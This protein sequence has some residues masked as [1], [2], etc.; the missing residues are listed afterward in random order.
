M[1]SRISAPYGPVRV[2]LPIRRIVREVGAAW[3]LFGPSRSFASYTVDIAASRL[4]RFSRRPASSL[5]HVVTRSGTQ[6]Y[7]RRNRG[8]IY[9]IKEIFMD[10]VYRLPSGHAPDVVVDLG[11]HIGLTTLWMA[12]TYKPSTI[13]AVEPAPSNAALARRNISA[14]GVHAEL[15]EAAIATSEGTA[16]FRE[17]PQSNLGQLSDIGT[18]VR[19][20]DIASVLARVPNDGRVDL[21]KIDIEGGESALFQGDV[22]WLSK[23]ELIVA[24]LHPNAADTI[25]ITTL[26]EGNGFRA[27]DLPGDPDAHTVCFERNRAR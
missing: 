12:E 25:A 3:R 26:L 8:D 10:D 2:A 19:T 11:A 9:A 22:S 15:V 14:N 24:E 17:D 21:L 6:I 1:S 23:V 7:Y 5:R 18:A 20:V 27:V 4:L 16:H 13:V